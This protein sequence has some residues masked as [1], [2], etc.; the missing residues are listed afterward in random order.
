VWK[1]SFRIFPVSLNDLCSNFHVQ[2]KLSK[3]N[4]HFN[5]IRVLIN[6]LLLR[7]LKS[8]AIQDSNCLFKAWMMTQ[9]LYLDE[10]GVYITSV[11]ST[12]TLSLKLFRQNSPRG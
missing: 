3:Y 1:D 7:K 6:Y 5:N 10:Y 12:S 2:G 4:I 11:L 8:Y 9:Y